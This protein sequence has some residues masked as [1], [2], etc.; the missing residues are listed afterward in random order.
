MLAT[1]APPKQLSMTLTDEQLASL[2]SIEG[3]VQLK[4][5]QLGMLCNEYRVNLERVLYHYEPL[6][7]PLRAIIYAG[8]QKQQYIET[9]LVWLERVIVLQERRGGT[10]TVPLRELK[11]IEDDLML[12]VNKALRASYQQLDVVTRE[13][14]AV[15]RDYECPPPAALATMAMALRVREDEDTEWSTVRVVLS[16]SYFFTFFISRAQTLLQRPLPPDVAD[17]LE[18]YC[19]APAHAPAALARVSVP[20]AAIGAWLHAVRDYHRVRRLCDPSLP[21]V[22]VEERRRTV[23]LLRHELQALKEDMHSAAEELQKLQQQITRKMFEVRSEYDDT[24]CTLHDVLEKKT[25]DFV[26]VLGGEELDPEEESNKEEQNQQEQKEGEEDGNAPVQSKES[27]IYMNV[28]E[29]EKEG[30][31]G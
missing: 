6:M 20:L 24:M 15:L 23:A 10:L 1:P 5:A 27:L 31:S 25:E 19:A 18:G 8:G 4:A 28:Q 30:G 17:A 2:L 11:A 16:E 22:A 29:K 21:P 14:L 9:Q 12:P 3:D 13:E 7:A 26:K